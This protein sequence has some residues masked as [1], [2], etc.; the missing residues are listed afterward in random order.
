GVEP[1]AETRHLY[2]EM[3]RRR[4]PRAPVHVAIF[5]GQRGSSA[6]D[7]RGPECIP[8]A[9]VMATPTTPLIGRD[10]DTKWLRQAMEEGCAGAGRLSG[11]V[12]EAGV[13]KTRLITEIATEAVQH[14]A[15]VLVGRGY[16]SDQILPFGPWVDAL[17]TSGVTGD[18]GLLEELSPA[19]RTE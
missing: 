7:R 13:G 12:G 2:Q 1:E 16:E 11:G 18:R 19:W 15:R 3:L 8:A 9:P 6:G 10:G 14:G 4:P 5:S 17:R